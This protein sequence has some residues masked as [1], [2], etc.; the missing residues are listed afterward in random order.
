MPLYSYRCDH[1][2]TI[3]DVMHKMKESYDESCENCAG[4]LNKYYGNVQIAPSVMPSRSN[5]DLAKTKANDAAKDVDMAAYKRLRKDGLQ[6]PSINGSAKLEARA[7]TKW[8]VN[9]GHTLSH[10]TRKQGEKTL[11]EHLG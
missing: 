8:E 11:Q 9:A 7:G 4:E 6:P 2:H 10:E 5:I 3:W 1:C